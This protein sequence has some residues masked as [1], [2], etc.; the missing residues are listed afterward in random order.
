[1]PR[2]FSEGAIDNATM[3][4]MGFTNIELFSDCPLD[5]NCFEICEVK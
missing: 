5:V 3:K 4:M 1:M 2:L